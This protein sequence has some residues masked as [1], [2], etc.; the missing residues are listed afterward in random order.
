[1]NEAY[2]RLTFLLAEQGIAP[3]ALRRR[4]IAKGEA[5]DERTLARLND[6]DRPVKHVQMR[7]AGA[8]CRALGIEL[9]ELFVFAPALDDALQEFPAE[10]QARLHEL[11]DQ[12]SEGQLDPQLLPELQLLVDEANDLEL[13]NLRRL[14]EHRE[15]LEAPSTARPHVAA[16]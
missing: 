6:P 1:M 10:K 7:V 12:H 5:I 3:D 15:R 16:D 4:L 14:V 11:M 2:S 8:I 13:V 9:G